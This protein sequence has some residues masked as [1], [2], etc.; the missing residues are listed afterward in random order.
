M[1]KKNTYFSFNGNRNSGIIVPLW[2]PLLKWGAQIPW[3]LSSFLNS[4]TL[5]MIL[6]TKYIMLLVLGMYF[7]GCQKFGIKVY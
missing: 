2:T 7:R 5:N 4:K 3:G 1:A 6:T